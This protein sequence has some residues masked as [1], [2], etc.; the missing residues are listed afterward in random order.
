MKH[1][2]DSFRLQNCQVRVLVDRYFPN[3]VF[4]W[5]K[6]VI[7][8]NCPFVSDFYIRSGGN[9]RNVNQFHFRSTK[10]VSEYSLDSIILRSEISIL[11]L[12]A[13]SLGLMIWLLVCT[14]M[15]SLTIR[16]IAIIIKM[17]CNKSGV[18]N[19]FPNLQTF[20]NFNYTAAHVVLGKY[21]FLCTQR[22]LSADRMFEGDK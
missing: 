5:E 10:I 7:I 14:V 21:P 19:R 20:N 17:L 15:Q 6:R 11:P 13:L 8:R 9:C 2:Q 16:S 22:N 1:T 18:S 12:N 4:E 3:N